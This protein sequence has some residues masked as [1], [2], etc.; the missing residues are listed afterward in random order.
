MDI[1][2]LQVFAVA[3]GTRNFTRAARTLG[4]SQANVTQQ[5]QQ[6]E[7]ELSVRL[8][9]RLGKKTSLT[10]AG[11]LLLRHAEGILASVEGAKAAVRDSGE[12]LVIGAAESLCAYRLPAVLGKFQARFP[13]VRTI[14]TLLD[15]ADYLSSLENNRVDVLFAL[16]ARLKAPGCRVVATRVE[17]VVVCARPGHPLTRGGW[18]QPRDF[19]DQPVL[20]TGEGCCYRAAFLRHLES[21]YVYPPVA[22]ETNSVHALKQAAL[23]GIGVGVLPDMAVAGELERGALAPLRVR[24]IKWNIVSQI[25]RHKDKWLSPALTGLLD[26]ATT[27]M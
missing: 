2:Q 8:F 22:M 7:K 9:E 25:V 13:A 16:G 15:C 5:I 23:S 19:A 6:L 27:E 12:T 1:R 11:E 20:L 17:K 14:I 26:I 10:H 21:Y 18:V 24:G 3:G 4:C